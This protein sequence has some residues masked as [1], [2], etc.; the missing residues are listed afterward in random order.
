[1]GSVFVSHSKHDENEIAFF[2]KIAAHSG[3]KTYLMEW[4]KME[5]QYAGFRIS[6]IIRSNLVEDIDVLVVLLGH[7]L[8]NPPSQQFTHNWV[9]FEVGASAGCRKPVIILEEAHNL[10]DFPIPYVTD[11]YQYEMNNVNDLRRIGEIIKR[12]T[13]QGW[14]DTHLTTCPYDNCNAKYNLWNR[15]SNRIHCPVC[16]QEILFEK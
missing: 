16:R 2:S 7:N 13:V 3:F 10:I 6:D 1:M 9:N 8:L 12:Y 15:Y 14:T 4:E 11:Y 5:N